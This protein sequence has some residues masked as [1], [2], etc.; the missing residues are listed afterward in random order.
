MGI[1]NIKRVNCDFMLTFK[2]K[3]ALFVH[4]CLVKMG[5]HTVA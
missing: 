5:V 4:F 1:K 3:C 2:V